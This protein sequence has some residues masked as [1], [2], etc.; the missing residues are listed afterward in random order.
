MLRSDENNLLSPQSKG[1]EATALKSLA[2]PTAFRKHRRKTAS[3][4]LGGRL[5]GRLTFL[6]G[7][8]QHAAVMTTV[9]T[10]AD[11]YTHIYSP[12]IMYATRH[13]TASSGRLKPP[14]RFMYWR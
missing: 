5:E 8:G 12:C 4:R 13:H 9:S 14:R 10:R 7:G 1:S 3:E 11:R 2:I 6:I